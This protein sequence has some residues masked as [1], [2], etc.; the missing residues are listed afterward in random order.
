MTTGSGIGKSFYDIKTKFTFLF[1]FKFWHP[2]YLYSAC[3]F[4][5]WFLQRYTILMYMYTWK[6]IVTYGGWLMPFHV[7]ESARQI[8]GVTKSRKMTQGR[9]N[10][11]LSC[12]RLSIFE[13]NTRTN[14]TLKTKLGNFRG[15]HTKGQIW[16]FVSCSDF[17]G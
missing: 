17:G 11:Y 8:V 6:S 12:V 15:E 9:N 14:E 2:F 4:I 16:T 13:T 5:K 1:N 10:V 7:F 3:M